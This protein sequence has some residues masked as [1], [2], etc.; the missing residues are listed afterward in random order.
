MR[1]LVFLVLLMFGASVSAQTACVPQVPDDF[2]MVC[3]EGHYHLLSPSTGV[4]LVLPIA[5]T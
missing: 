2:S 1:A 5:C 4:I 3:Y